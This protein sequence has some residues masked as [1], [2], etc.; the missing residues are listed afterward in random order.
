MFCRQC[1]SKIPNEA[2]FCTFCGTKTVAPAARQNADAQEA[3]A[4]EAE[5]V[6]AANG[7]TSEAQN[8]T[9]ANAESKAVSSN[10]VSNQIAANTV[11]TDN[12][13]PEIQDASN[14]LEQVAE[15]NTTTE[16]QPA[17]TATQATE[18]NV[19]ASLEPNNLKA[20]VA[21]NK[22][23]SRRH[24]PMIVLVALALALATSVAY[25]AYRVYTDVWVPYQAE[26]QELAK[27]PLKDADGDTITA[28]VSGDAK[29][30]LQIADLMMM[31]PATI[32][33]FLDEQGLSYN[34]I[35]MTDEHGNPIEY[36]GGWTIPQFDYLNDAC[37]GIFDNNRY[38]GADTVNLYIGSK[39]N[40]VS[41][42][43][44]GSTASKQALKSGTTQTGV[45]IGFLPIKDNPSDDEIASFCS[46][47]KLG[48]PLEKF[49]TSASSTNGSVGAK[50]TVYTGIAAPKDTSEKIVW[51]LSFNAFNDD[52][53]LLGCIKLE[54]AY[55]GIVEPY[56]LYSE[57]QWN[58]ASN[59]EKA[60]IAAQSLSEEYWGG[61]TS[62]RFNVLTKKVE[63]ATSDGS[64][65]EAEPT[66]DKAVW[67]SPNDGLVI[68]EK[69]VS[70]NYALD[71][72]QSET[73]DL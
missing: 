12:N 31:D 66:N 43:E 69:D 13:N 5:K 54:D 3:T 19:A 46:A 44:L 38:K 62:P 17:V 1:G 23:R 20:A 68:F 10:A 4:T 24:I 61:F 42:H 64:W 27:H 73:T 34:G 39:T 67:I 45:I 58:S 57:D 8:D 59:R 37:P 50:T 26:Q 29:N 2:K 18:T 53:Y 70:G 16:M 11:G 40:I 56:A 52:E 48:A 14:E 41:P 33:D 63:V 47:C 72:F 60:K 9:A 35:Q 25:A 51:Y 22:K 71:T 28:E 30:A 15:A 32:P 55:E 65:A 7:S 21:Q 49:T 36:G 6:T